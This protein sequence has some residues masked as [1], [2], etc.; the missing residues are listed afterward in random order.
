MCRGRGYMGKLCTLLYC[1]PKT[2]L[3]NEV[4]KK[5]EIRHTQRA[6]EVLPWRIKNNINLSL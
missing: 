6:L 1:K 4:L 3:K 2:T 5:K